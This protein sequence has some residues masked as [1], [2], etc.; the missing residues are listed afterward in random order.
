MPAVVVSGLGF[1]TKEKSTTKDV[2]ILELTGILGGGVDSEWFCCNWIKSDYPF[3]KTRLTQVIW[4]RDSNMFDGP[5]CSPWRYWLCLQSQVK[6]CPGITS[7]LSYCARFGIV[8]KINNTHLVGDFNPFEKYQSNWKSFPHRGENKNSLKPPPSHQFW[9]VGHRDAAIQTIKL[10]EKPTNEP[11]SERS[12][13][14]VIFW[15]VKLVKL[16][17]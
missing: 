13:F 15:L 9:L 2:I 10:A 8:K 6:V 17:G 3:W 4:R 12:C 1:Q 11:W 16:I 7:L 14:K 5:S